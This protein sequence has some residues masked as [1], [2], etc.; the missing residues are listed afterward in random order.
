MEKAK[1][2]LD[3]IN[4]IESYEKL[5]KFNDDVED[6]APAKPIKPNDIDYVDKKLSSKFLTKLANF[7]GVAFFESM[8]KN[9]SNSTN[10]QD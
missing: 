10:G 7:L 6:D 5:G 4:K 3:V 2:R 9:K 8:I 1:D